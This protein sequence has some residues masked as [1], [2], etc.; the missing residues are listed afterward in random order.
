MRDIDSTQVR[1]RI[2]PI[3]VLNPAAFGAGARDSMLDD[4]M[5]VSCAFVEGAGRRRGL[6]GITHRIANFVHTAIW[7]HVH[8]VIDLHSGDEVARFMLRTSFHPIDNPEQRRLIKEAARWFGTPLIM[9]CRSETPGLLPSEAE[10][11]SRIIM[12]RELGWSTA[13]HADGIALARG[14]RA[15]ELQD[16]QILAIGNLLG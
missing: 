8:V 2:I 10:R 14:W 1:S 12:G 6:A 7:P 9:T 11:L 3:S 5:N 16:R 13:V 15:P 4:R